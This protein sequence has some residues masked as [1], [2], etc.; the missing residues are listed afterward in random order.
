MTHRAQKIVDDFGDAS[1][2]VPVASGEARL[3]LTSEPGPLGNA[4]GMEFDFH[5]GGGFVVARREI[6]MALPESYTFAFH[7]RGSAPRNTLEFKLVDPTGKNVWRWQEENFAFTG[8]GRV[9]TIR[10]SQIPFAWGPA[11][12]GTIRNLS[13]IE[14]V[15]SAGSGGKGMVWIEDFR[16]E[17]RSNPFPP[18]ISAS[19]SA[20]GTAPDH[21]LAVKEPDVWR[22]APDDKQPWVQL[23]FY[24]PREYGGLIVAWAEEPVT[25]RYFV[26]ASDDLSAWRLL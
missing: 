1:L 22:S 24:A 8:E 20:S 2:W 12:G 17:D 26:E 5:G 6:A 25:K 7:V 23:D 19:S 15:I 14:F 18:A 21:V 13:A 4:L 11:G 16:L 10:N 3:T 9:I